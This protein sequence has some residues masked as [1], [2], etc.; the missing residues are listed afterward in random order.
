M[1]L[2]KKG[3]KGANVKLV[4]EWLNLHGFGL[5]IDGDFGPAT[6]HGVMLFQNHNILIVDGIVGDKTFEKLIEPMAKANMSRPA[7]FQ[8][9]L[10]PSHDLVVE[11]AKQHLRQKPKE[12]GGQNMGPWVRMYMDGYEGNAWPWCAG[13][14]CYVL[15]QAYDELYKNEDKGNDD[16]IVS[17]PFIK[18]FSVDAIVNDAIRN[19]IFY[20]ENEVKKDK[21]IPG[22]FYVIRKEW[23]DWI[24]IG[25]IIEVRDKVFMAIEGN[26]NS[27]G[28]REGIEVALKIR[29]YKNKD[30]IIY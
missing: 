13:F 21:I 15:Q 17:M 25:I 14:V 7:L 12:V 8:G 30:F 9:E 6:E 20:K 27:K 19:G 24:H 23:G 26:T 1:V 11:Y 5:A 3:S 10:I 2:I 22:S 4:Q 18:S 29:S 16:P 28:E